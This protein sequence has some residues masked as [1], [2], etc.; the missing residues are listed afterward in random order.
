MPV[1]RRLERMD[2]TLSDPLIGGLLYGRSR[3]EAPIAH[4]GMA[5]L[6]TALDPRVGRIVALQVL[7]PTRALDE[8]FAARFNR[9]AKAAAGLAGAN[10]G[11]VHDQAERGGRVVVPMESE[12]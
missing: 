12:E 3:V 9:E 10:D 11:A 1:T 2:T 5:C 7:H 6:Y 8:G 4:A